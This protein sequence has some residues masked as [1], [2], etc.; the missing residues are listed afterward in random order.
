MTVTAF[1]FSDS[2]IL[3]GNDSTRGIV[4]VEPVASNRMAVYLRPDSLITIREEVEYQPW[5]IAVRAEPWLALRPQPVVERLNGEQRLSFLV[6]FANWNLFQ[7][8]IRAAR[9]SREV[10]HEVGSP[11]DQYLMESGRTLFK[12]MVFEDLRRMQLDIETTGLDPDD[13]SAR[14]VMIA[15]KAYDGREV[16]FADDDEATMLLELTEQ[17][18]ELDPDVLEGHNI[19]NFDIPYLL[20][21]AEKVGIKLRWGRDHSPLRMGQRTQRFK[22][23]ALTLPY[24]PAYIHGR[25]I[26]DTYQQ[27]QRYDV[28][29]HL[30]SY[31]LKPAIE[32]LGM[33]RS[34][35]EFVPGHEIPEIWKSDRDRLFRYAIDDVR[36]VNLLSQLTLPTEFY[37]SQ[38][39]PR[40]FQQVATTGP[41]GKIDDLMLRAYLHSRE[42]VPTPSPAKGYPGGHT[43]LLRTGVFAP[44]VKC[45][46][47]SLYPSIMMAEGI[48]SRQDSLGVFLP[49]L[50]ELTRRRL[51]AKAMSRSTSGQEQATWEGLQGSFKVLINSFYGYLGFGAALF[52]DFDA[53]GKVTIAGQ[54]IIK[55]IVV[56]LTESG[57]VPIEVDT[58]GVYFVPPSDVSDPESEKQYIDQIGAV[59]PLGIRLAHDGHYEAMLSLRL[60]NYALLDS[61]DRLTLKGSALRSRRFETCFRDFLIQAARAFMTDQRLGARDRYFALAEAIKNRALGITQISQWVMI[62]EQTLDSQPRL[63]SLLTRSPQIGRAGERILVYEREDGALATSTDYAQDENT[64][65]L[66]RRLHD[67]AKRFDTLFPTPQEFTSFFPLITSRTDIEGART[68]ES[69]TQMSLF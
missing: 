4:A 14:I 46:V 54:E 45:D 6:R 39:L 37:Q 21:R 19:F 9:E 2:T 7:D 24:R 5:L 59:L 50:K 44:V 13:P 11:V 69:S 34:D 58:D 49:M 20:A 17:I 56:R 18:A 1:G 48:T 29:G 30:S 68:Q 33:T 63:K 31:G 10:M 53:A 28:G 8:A 26:V 27:I 67:T 47:E 66:L 60:K 43:E 38:L 15:M 41:G 42:S 40:A 23:G 55:S 25:H 57:A 52:N 22:A 62:N 12:G 35:R 64:G 65:Y 3:N 32:A 51:H 36:D 16:V 61:D